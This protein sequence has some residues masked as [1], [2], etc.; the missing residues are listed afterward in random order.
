MVQNSALFRLFNKPI[1]MGPLQVPQTYSSHFPLFFHPSVL[2]CFVLFRGYSIYSLW[3]QI[4][5]GGEEITKQTTLSLSSS[6]EAFR[7][8]RISS[9]RQGLRSQNYLLLAASLGHA[10][11]AS[12]NPS[13][14]LCNWRILPSS[15]EN[16]K[17]S[18][19]REATDGTG[20]WGMWSK[21]T[22]SSFHA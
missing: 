21:G 17:E 12:V 13:F 14:L 5:K 3:F 19:W 10:H 4:L 22:V 6:S 2:F 20:S 7:G 8:Q 11:L 16:C 18:V 15:L 1:I 9:N